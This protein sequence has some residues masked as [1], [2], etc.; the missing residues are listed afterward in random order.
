MKSLS[1]R[2]WLKAISCHHALFGNWM[3]IN[4]FPIYCSLL[5][6]IY[7]SQR[8]H[9]TSV[10][11]RQR[12]PR[13]LVSGQ[14]RNPDCPLS[15][16]KLTSH[17]TTNSQDIWSEEV[18]K[19]WRGLITDDPTFLQC[20]IQM[21]YLNTDITFKHLVSCCT[22]SHFQVAHRYHVTSPVIFQMLAVEA[23]VEKVKWHVQI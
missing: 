13:P 17:E 2:G 16:R 9:Q 6:P 5:S 21:I 19:S 4:F 22:S 7:G 8:R 1:G 20:S 10:P 23:G 18:R 14:A 12:L 11:S 3:L 15:C